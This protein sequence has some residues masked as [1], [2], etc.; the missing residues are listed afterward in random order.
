MTHLPYIAASYA[1]G[2]LV[3]AAFGIGA[4]TRAAAARRKLRAVDP[5]FQAREAAR[6]G[7]PPA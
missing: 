4:W 7:A 5:R 2:I 3:P 6:R 1:I